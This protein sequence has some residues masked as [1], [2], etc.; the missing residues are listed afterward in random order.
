M[1]HRSLLIGIIAFAICFGISLVKNSS[2]EHRLEKMIEQVNRTPTK[3]TIL[4]DIKDIRLVDKTVVYTFKLDA[5]NVDITEFNKY[6]NLLKE[7]GKVVMSIED[8]SMDEFIGLVA[9]CDGY[10]LKMVY[11][12]GLS[13]T[14]EATFT[15]AEIMEARA[16]RLTPKQGYRKMVE[17]ELEAM[18]KEL[19]MEAEK[20]INITEVNVNDVCLE[21]ICMVDERL[22]SMSAII[23][24]G[25][26]MKQSMRDGF[27]QNKGMWPLLTSLT[28]AELGLRYAY[29]G[30]VSGKEASVT[31][32]PTEISSLLAKFEREHNTFD[33]K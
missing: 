13:G 31:F 5:A 28:K 19:P 4:G 21:Y 18:R 3:S 24:A 6:S 26:E 1:K 8:P 9:Q 32:A 7:R 2:P 27:V 15:H 33:F 17:I 30:T 11:D 23:A 10:S 22:Y 12:T 20:G 16:N 29:R 14:K 25:D